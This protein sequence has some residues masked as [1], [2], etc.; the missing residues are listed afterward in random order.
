MDFAKPHVIT[1]PCVHTR[2]PCI[3]SNYYQNNQDSVGIYLDLLS[4]QVDTS[5]NQEAYGLMDNLMKI[6]D[7]ETAILQY[8]T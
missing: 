8:L 1:S 4:H 3:S 5:N 7:L 6:A 2:F